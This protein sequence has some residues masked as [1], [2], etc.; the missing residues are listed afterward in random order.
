M[1]AR[2]HAAGLMQLCRCQV[3]ALSKTLKCLMVDARKEHWLWGLD[4]SRG[5]VQH[6]ESSKAT[7]PKAARLRPPVA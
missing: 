5:M 4:E 3:E 7:I 1:D 6:S 2:V